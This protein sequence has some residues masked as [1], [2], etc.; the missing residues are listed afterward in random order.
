MVLAVATGGPPIR[1]RISAKHLR[2]SGASALSK[3]IDA[4]RILGSILA[5]IASRPT[6]SSHRVSVTL[7]VGLGSSVAQR[8]LRISSLSRDWQAM[9]SL[10]N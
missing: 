3:P 6:S 4:G 8:T 1:F 2:P 7:E 9:A 10:A 5:W